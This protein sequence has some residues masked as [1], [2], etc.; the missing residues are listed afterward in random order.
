[1]VGIGGATKVMIIRRISPAISLRRNSFFRVTFVIYFL[2]E[3]F[4]VDW[5]TVPVDLNSKRNS[6]DRKSV[7]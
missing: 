4:Q 5:R 1:M 7:V 2:F 6:R 3:Q